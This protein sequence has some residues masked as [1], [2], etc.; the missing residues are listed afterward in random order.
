[1][2]QTPTCTAT[3]TPFPGPTYPCQPVSWTGL[4]NVTASGNTI[5]KT[6]GLSGQWDAGAISVQQ[7]FSGDGY[8]QA[9]IVETNTFAMFGLDQANTTTGASD[10]DFAFFTAGEST[11]IILKIYESGVLR[12][13]FGSYSVGDVLKVAVVGG[14]VR[15]YRNDVL[16]HTSTLTP[17]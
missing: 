7:I 9:S 5:T 8:A 12:G 10:T 14:R 11:G 4:V 2:D 15:Y 16:L 6:G 3:S 1:M 13:N 17:T